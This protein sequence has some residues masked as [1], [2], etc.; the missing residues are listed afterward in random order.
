MTC[1]QYIDLDMSIPTNP[2]VYS[3]TGDTARQVVASLYN[4]GVVWDVPSGA[5]G[6][7]YAKD[8]AGNTFSS[9]TV[10]FEDN[11]ATI[12]LPTFT[13]IG[14]AKGEI[15]VTADGVVST[16]NFRIATYQSA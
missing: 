7:V 9:N 5:T 15:A 16:F 3:K 13:G 1:I 12:T 11:Q 14:N 2:I 10:S 8:C 6:V 4:Q